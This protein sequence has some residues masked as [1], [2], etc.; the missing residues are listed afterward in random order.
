MQVRKEFSNL[1]RIIFLTSIHI[2]YNSSI[3][4]GFELSFNSVIEDLAV[5]NGQ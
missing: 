3:Q 2:P 5:I 4:K 1:F